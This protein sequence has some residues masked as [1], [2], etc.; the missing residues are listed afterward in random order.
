MLPKLDN[1]VAIDLPS[2]GADLTPVADVTLDRYVDAIV[3]EINKHQEPVVLVG[4]SAAGIAIASVAERIPD[5]IARLVYVCAYAPKNGDAL[6]QIRKRAKRQL[7]LPAII[8]SED[9]L[10]YTIN[11]KLGVGV[12]YHDCPPEA[13]EFALENLG[14]QPTLPQQTP[15]TLSAKYDSVPRSY[16]LGKDDHAVPPEEQERMVADWS[17]VDVHRMQCG[18]SPFFSHPKKL[19]Q[20]LSEITGG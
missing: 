6:H 16:I 7:V 3:L 18:H 9:G 20:I 11:P 13:G 8:K 2:H 12:F 15:V 5:R 14:A 4:H 1:A 19:V 17:A 10:S